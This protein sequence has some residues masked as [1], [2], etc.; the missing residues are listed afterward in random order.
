[1]DN[2]FSAARERAL[3]EAATAKFLAHGGKIARIEPVYQ[4]DKGPDLTPSAAKPSH[5][6]SVF[7][8]GLRR[9]H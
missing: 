8:A 2:Q 4:R 1:M 7:N 3:L 9:P 6:V 5:P